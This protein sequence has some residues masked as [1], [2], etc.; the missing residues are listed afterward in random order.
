MD[1]KLF[2][3]R[4]Q[5][6]EDGQFAWSQWLEDSKS[7]DMSRISGRAYLE[8]NMLTLGRWKVRASSEFSNL[9]EVSEY[10]DTLP[11][12]D[13]TTYFEVVHDIGGIEQRSCKTGEPVTYEEAYLGEATK[14]K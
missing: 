14:Q 8:G 12:W 9:S 6:S 2:G 10:L 1:W 11:Q 5:E 13:R 4:I 3:S 7:G